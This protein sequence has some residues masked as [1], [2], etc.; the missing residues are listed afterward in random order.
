MRD[1]RLVRSLKGSL[2]WV[3]DGLC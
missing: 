3:L 2:I 1:Q